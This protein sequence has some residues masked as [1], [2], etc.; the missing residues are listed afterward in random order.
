MRRRRRK[1]QPNLPVL[2]KSSWCCLLQGGRGQA[3]VT[4][5]RR[6][7]SVSTLP[8]SIK[9]DTS[10]HFQ[11]SQAPRVAWSHGEDREPSKSQGWHQRKLR[12]G[13]QTASGKEALPGVFGREA[14]HF[15]PK[16]FPALF[17]YIP[18]SAAGFSVLLSTTG[19]LEE[20]F[21]LAFCVEEPTAN[22]S[23]RQGR[24]RMGTLRKGLKDGNW[25][26]FI[27]LEP[28][29]G[30]KGSGKVIREAGIQPG[31]LEIPACKTFTKTRR[32]TRCF[33]DNRSGL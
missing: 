31:C 22:R 33:E 26:D 6:C 8:N 5:P 23:H 25:E 28:Q 29:T 12:K 2:P 10:K 14:S 3:C 7:P 4:P 20:P 1:E 32:R 17:D 9:P 19:R 15:S 27:Q 24:A 16:V 13:S 30:L 18:Q 21:V 11:F